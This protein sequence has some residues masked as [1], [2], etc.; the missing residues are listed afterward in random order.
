MF[1]PL[2]G[3]EPRIHTYQIT[4]LNGSDDLSRLNLS[5]GPVGRDYGLVPGTDDLY[6]GVSD[7]GLFSV[8][9]C[10]AMEFRG[11]T[12]FD[13]SMLMHDYVSLVDGQYTES[14]YG[15]NQ[16]DGDGSGPP[17]THDWDFR[18]GVYENYI[19]FAAMD[20]AWF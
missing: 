1:E 7:P 4:G 19:D 2:P 10:L 18:L 11:N 13:L 20:P 6:L 12:A 16:P 3:S 15:D 8:P 5:N 14:F 17:G 9:V